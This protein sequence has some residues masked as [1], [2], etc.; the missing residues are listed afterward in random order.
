MDKV[1]LITGSNKG[2][3][4]EIARQCGKLGFQ[5][6]VSGRDES[7]LR[8]AVEMLAKDN[9]LADSLLMDVSSN[10]SIENAVK[11]FATRNI[12]LDVLVNNAAIGIHEDNQLAYNNTE[13][14]ER[15]LQTNSFGPLRVTKA[16]IPYIRR[17]GRIV[18]ISSSGGVLNGEV[19]G[20]SPAY[21]SSKT[22][23]NAITKHL[24]HELHPHNISVNAVCPGW[25]KTDMGGSG[26]TRSVE[27]GAETPVWLASE[28]PQELTGQ[29]LRD[30]KAILW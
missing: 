16:F 11:L 23:L 17:P 22:L 21:C 24:G 19:G 3:G 2:I 30:K 8:K 9:V 27:K 10:E 14:L 4:Y 5:V 1:I 12:E 26:A 20:W 25:V 18:M 6:I 28:A 15:S 7:R 29:F 13:I